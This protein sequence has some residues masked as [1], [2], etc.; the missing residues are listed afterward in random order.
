[1][2]KDYWSHVQISSRGAVLPEQ[3]GKP[4]P[5]SRAVL[6]FLQPMKL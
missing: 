5:L 2:Q 1:M 3:L 6:E 4:F